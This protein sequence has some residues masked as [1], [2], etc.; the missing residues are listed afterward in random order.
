M[1]DFSAQIEERD[2][3]LIPKG[4]LLWAVINLKGV[5][6]S[7]SSTSK[8]L[9]MELTIDDGQPYARRKIF[10][11]VGDPNWQ[12]NSEEYR[13]MGYGAIRRILEAA[14]GAH[15]S[16]PQSYLVIPDPTY[17]VLHGKRVAVKVTIEKGKDGYED[18]NSVEFL[19]PHSSVKS[20][21]KAFEDLKAG[22]HMAEGAANQSGNQ[23]ANQ[24]AGQPA[25]QGGFFGQN[26]AVGAAAP[27][28]GPSWLGQPSAGQPATQ[29]TDDEIPF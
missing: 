6:S 11:K 25:Q 15:P 9:D 5:K 1:L 8:Y 26:A 16:N 27:A 10:V 2:Y 24:S 12:G 19:S 13:K 7:N 29:G 21:A 17:H 23:S 14:F 18:K 22:K 20:V 3:D 4:T 28:S